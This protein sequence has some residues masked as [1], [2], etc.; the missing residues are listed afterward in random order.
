MGRGTSPPQEPHPS[1]PFNLSLFVPSSL[2]I[3]VDPTLLYR[4]LGTNGWRC[5]LGIRHRP[6]KFIT[7]SVH[8]CLQHV[9]RDTASEPRRVLFAVLQGLR[10]STVRRATEDISSRIQPAAHISLSAS[11][12]TQYGSELCACA[13]QQDST[14]GPTSASATTP[15][16]RTVLL[17]QR[18]AAAA[19]CIQ[20]TSSVLTVT[21]PTT[22]QLPVYRC[23]RSTWKLR[24]ASL[25][26]AASTSRCRRRDYVF[27]VMT[28]SRFPRSFDWRLRVQTYQI[29]TAR[30]TRS[31][32]AN[33]AERRAK[34]RIL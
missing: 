19:A 9:D 5:E 3:S 33:T 11:M 27:G 25:T 26:Q 12:S 32:Q 8:V 18:A 4:R 23:R 20:L 24:R 10:G 29:S 16:T 14:S 13:V 6:S 34:R 17:H 2:A 31:G 30:Y 21:R 22:S 7:V 15:S 1:G 28:G